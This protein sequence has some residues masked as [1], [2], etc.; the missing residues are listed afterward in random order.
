MM[1][2]TELKLFYKL[3][4]LFIS[5]LEPKHQVL[6]CHSQLKWTL[7]SGCRKLNSEHTVTS[8]WQ[9]RLSEKTSRERTASL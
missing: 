3:M 9:R 6:N 2:F 7:F 4:Q 8:L 5:L 1:I